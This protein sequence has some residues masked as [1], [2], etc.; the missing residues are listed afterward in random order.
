MART[1]AYSADFDK[2]IENL[3][4]EAKLLVKDIMELFMKYLGIEL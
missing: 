3:F 4:K 2:D 1:Y